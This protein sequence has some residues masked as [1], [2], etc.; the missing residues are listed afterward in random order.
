MSGTGLWPSAVPTAR[1]AFGRPISAA[2]QPYGRTSPRGISSAF[3][4]TARSNSV[5][6]AQ[7]EVDP[8]RGGRRRG[9]ARSFRARR[10]GSASTALAPTRPVRA[11]KPRL[12]RASSGASSTVETPRPFQATRSGPIG[13]SI[14][15]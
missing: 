13:E 11:K 6:P 15:A 1:T 5:V 9:G 10:G 14:T 3:I 2:I 4:Q 7:V 8:V 12:E